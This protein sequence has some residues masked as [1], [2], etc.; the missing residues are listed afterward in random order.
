MEMKLFKKL[1]N[2]EYLDQLYKLLEIADKEFVPALS[3]RSSTTQQTLQ[4]GRGEG[5]KDYFEE[6]KQQA[7]VLA[8]D[9]NRVA[10]FMSFRFDHRCDYSPSGPNLYAS[11][12]VVHPDYRGKGLMKG[13]YTAM[14]R[15]YP[16]RAIFTRTWEENKVHLRVLDKLGFVMTARLENH[17][18]PGIHTVYFERKADR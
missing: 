6:M 1:E 18:G 10:G 16:D 14:I 9:G 2:P 15:A 12:S 11:T 13:F 3:S 5:L 4:G 17:R 7:F 8:M